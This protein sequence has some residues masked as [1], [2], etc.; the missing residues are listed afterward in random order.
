MLHRVGLMLGLAL[1]GVL[2][3]TCT[4]GPRAGDAPDRRGELVER[5]G[6]SIGRRGDEIVVAGR[7]FHTGVPVVLWSDPGG[8]DAYR[9][10]RVFARA[11]AAA[12]DGGGATEQRAARFGTRFEKSLD[13]GMLALVRREGWTL[14]ELRERVDQFV[15]HYD[16]CG[17]SRACFR[18]LHDVRG[19]SVHFMID[20]DG[21]I[22][23]TLDVQERA[24]HAT[25][26]NDRSVGVEIANIGAYGFD[27]ADPFDRWY[28]IDERGPRITIPPDQGDGGLRNPHASL[29]PAR[30]EIVAGEVH[31]R[32]LR[33]FDYTPE[34]YES[35]AHLSAALSVALPRI[36]LEAPRDASGRVLT[37]ALSSE[38]WRA[39]H[40]ILGH[41]HVQ[42][43]KA[44]PGPAMDWDGVLRRA[45]A[46]RSG[47]TLGGPAPVAR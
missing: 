16:A 5:P 38:E 39:F 2:L 18:V 7:F 37:R 26:A 21:T 20:V 25:I 11:G 27:E 41:D 17:T 13:A 19:L 8:Y 47:V 4:S 1:F 12:G 44:D 30:R 46:V 24:W 14:D 43:N 35:L 23:Q 29:R 3:S 40:G 10:D 36:A 15:L 28:A 32:V 34:Q 45:R 6:D 33:Q 9:T 31:G 22:Y 42:E